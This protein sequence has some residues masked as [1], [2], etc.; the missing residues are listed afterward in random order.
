M[1]LLRSR[2]PPTFQ[3]ARQSVPALVIAYPSVRKFCMQGTALARNTT[4]GGGI[5]SVLRSLPTFYLSRP[6]LATPLALNGR[7]SP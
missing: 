1:P 6:A 4:K 7:Q 3:R 5:E 2:L